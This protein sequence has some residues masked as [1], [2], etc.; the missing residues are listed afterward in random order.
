MLMFDVFIIILGF[1]GE[2]CSP[3]LNSPGF[4]Q[5]SFNESERGAICGIKFCLF[6]YH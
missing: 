1:V 4:Q 6:C 2:I 5:I 3:N